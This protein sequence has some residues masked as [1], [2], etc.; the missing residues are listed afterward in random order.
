MAD[1]KRELLR[2]RV[3]AALA[4]AEEAFQG[5]YK[6][7]LDELLGLSSA[8]LEQAAP[9]GTSTEEYNKL[10]SV[11]REASRINAKQADLADHIRN[12]GATAVRIAGLVPGLAKVL[13][14]G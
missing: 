5:E 12:L 7:E 10:I 1:D 14:L 9:G 6:E 2:R 3:R 11:V 13:T 4:R 8:D